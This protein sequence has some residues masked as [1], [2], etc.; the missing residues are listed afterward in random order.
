[1]GALG[2]IVDLLLVLLGFSLIIVLHE[3]GHFLAARWAGIRVLAF[4]MGFGPAIFSFRKGMGL[5]LGSSDQAYAELVTARGG[6]VPF[7]EVSPTEYRWNWLPLGGYVRMLGQDDADPSARSEATDSYQ[8]CVPW[9]RMIVISAGVVMNVITAAVLFVI[10]F[11]AGLRTEP[12]TI[13]TVD[14]GSPAALATAVNAAEVGVTTPGLQPGDKVV[15]IAGKAPDSF[16][17]ITI[18]T[19]MAA[20]GQPV[21]IEVE[22]PGVAGTLRFEVTPRP[23]RL[24]GL[25]AIG[26]G[27]GVS[28][29]LI[30]SPQPAERDEIAKALDRL[31]VGEAGVTPGSTL[32]AVGGQPVVTP[33]ALVTAARASGG[34]PLQATFRTP[35]GR[36][37][38]AAIGTEAEL[39]V[40][41]FRAPGVGGEVSEQAATHVLGLVPGL[42]VEAIPANAPPN[43]LRAGDVFV[44]LG[45]VPWPGLIDGIAEIRRH[46]GRTIPIVVLRD[47]APVDL[48]KVA[49]SRQ[50]TV[51]FGPGTTDAHSP[52][53][54]A[55][56]AARGSR[57]E[58]IA[59]DGTAEQGPSGAGL[60]LVPGSVVQS[61]SIGT[62]EPVAVASLGAVREVLRAASIGVV[63][64]LD[65][66]LTVRLPDTG[67]SAGTTETVRWRVPEAEVRSLSSLAWTPA[68]NPGLFAREEFLLRADSPFGAVAMGLRETHR[69]MIQTYLTF[70]RLFQGTVK[71]EHLKGPVGIAHFGTLLADR[72]FIWL[73]FFMAVISVNLAVI[74]FLPLPIVDGGHFCF[75]L[76][77]QLTGKPVSVMVQNIAAIAGLVLIGTVFLIV[78]Y[79]DLA[80]L[81]W[82]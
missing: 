29:A 70:A 82:R 46:A 60:G 47:G 59:R 17:D 52:R 30:N 13:G 57:I 18:E 43:G 55:W 23:D 76:W 78:T 40:Q 14:V 26:V 20:K 50:G 2:T 41:R 22:R 15:A 7:N 3:L 73:L 61:V 74:N 12:P 42:K 48:G 1:M 8:N 58:A 19:A 33:Q 9:K 75:L 49:V 34:A 53:V 77:E 37:V 6:R 44:R 68:L 5:R 39:P 45:D 64:G 36:E 11:T 71:V 62:G 32:V 72:G 28:T 10:V 31:G 69:V 35:E 79:N 51:G 56:P 16:K 80:N 54:S 27:P 24:S 67:G 65:V 63:G 4:A 38:V 21:A 81:L 66:A 25:L